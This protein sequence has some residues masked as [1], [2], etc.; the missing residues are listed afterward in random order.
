[1][2]LV[3]RGIN[4]EKRTNL[5]I[6]SENEVYSCQMIIIMK[7]DTYQKLAAINPISGYPEN[8]FCLVGAAVL[9]LISK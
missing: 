2:P 3:S 8:R 7:Y 9:N 4:R 1:M 5:Q 6:S